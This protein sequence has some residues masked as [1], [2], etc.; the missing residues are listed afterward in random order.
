MYLWNEKYVDIDLKDCD[1]QR[2]GRE[3]KHWSP[4]GDFC[5]KQFSSFL[6]N[7]HR[8]S[9]GTGSEAA[10]TVSDVFWSSCWEKIQKIHCASHYFCHWRECFLAACPG[11]GT[12]PLPA[13]GPG[14]SRSRGG[15]NAP[16]RDNRAWKISRYIRLQHLKWI[17]NTMMCNTKRDWLRYVACLK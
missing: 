4:N 1:P 9:P 5:P 7:G 12:S 14:D 11:R 13:P 8:A 2:S 15:K 3:E 16:S 6:G 17:S 10:C